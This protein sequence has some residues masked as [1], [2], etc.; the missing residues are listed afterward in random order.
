MTAAAPAA[1]A[2]YTP[3]QVA[4]LLGI[5]HGKVIAWIATG[6]LVA[7]DIS[8]SV[9]GRPRWRISHSALT[10][11]LEGRQSRPPVKASRRRKS[12]DEGRYY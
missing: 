8:Q 11:F 6:E 3:P 12:A 1:Q 5:D 10:R 2:F 7:V 9:G 4:E